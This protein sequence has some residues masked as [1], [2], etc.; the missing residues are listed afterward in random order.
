MKALFLLCLLIGSASAQQTPGARLTA[1]RAML[2]SGDVD[3]AIRVTRAIIQ[4]W[5]TAARAR[6]LL[7]QALVS[8]GKTEEAN[9]ILRWVASHGAAPLATVARRRLAGT[10]AQIEWGVRARTGAAYDTAVLPPGARDPSSTADARIELGAAV[11]ARR[12]AWDAALGID[13]T[14]HLEADDADATILGLVNRLQLGDGANRLQLVADAQALFAE[15]VPSLHHTL[16]G[17]GATWWRA[18]TWSPFVQAGAHWAAYREIA[19]R[20]DADQEA[21]LAGATG[22]RWLGGRETL[23]LRFDGRWVGPDDTTGFTDLGAT[24]G[25]ALQWGRWRLDAH[26]GYG[27]RWTDLGREGRLRARGAVGWTPIA[28]WTLRADVR[29]LAAR[30]DTDSVDRLIT[31]LSLEVRR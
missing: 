27:L 15:R 7:A 21:R 14:L 17:G 12:T 3:G 8:Q 28:G 18:Q 29:W 11:T 1:A 2:Q 13:R 23:S 26:G 30:R 4:T 19:D 24:F 9:R 22:L 16:L 25:G 6:L 5:P 31:G 20:P 10:S